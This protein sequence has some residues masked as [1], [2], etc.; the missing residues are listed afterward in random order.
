[1]RDDAVYLAYMAESIRRVTRYVA[2]PDGTPDEQ[3]FQSDER[4]QD[5][6]LRRMETLADAAGQLSDELQQRYPEIPWQTIKGFRNVIAHDHTE[7]DLSLVWQAI[8]GLP[9]LEAVVQKELTG[10]KPETEGLSPRGSA[11]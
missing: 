7:I 5:A 3:L 8:Q 9:S 2:G 10:T 4:T 11:G 6:V 1:M